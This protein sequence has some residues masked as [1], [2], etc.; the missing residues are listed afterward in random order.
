MLLNLQKH[1]LFLFQML[2]HIGL[3]YGVFNFKLDEWLMVFFIYFLTGCL[4]VSITYHRYLS[5]KSFKTNSLF[6]K[7]GILLATYGIVGSSLAWVNNHRK[8]HR[9]TDKQGDPHSPM[10]YGY[11]KTQWLSMY[12]SS[13]TMKYVLEYINDDFQVLIHRYYYLIHA[14]ILM[15]FLV[16][17]DI[18]VTSI[19][20]LA[21]AAILW[22]M[23][24][25][26]NTICHN[27][28]GY[29]NHILKDRSTNNFLLGVF[30]WGEGWHNNHHYMP[31]RP[32]F[33]E[34]WFEIDISYLIIQLIKK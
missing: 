15:L 21:P 13:E 5:H 14:L 10:I 32:K 33:G 29:K 1:L 2:A 23:G 8:H 20:Y 24:S 4:G 31:A 7:I 16:F 3:I 22:N 12:T 30:V 34:R 19:Y 25:M 9:Y 26:I 17:T 6:S 11:L 18:H 28:L 27:S